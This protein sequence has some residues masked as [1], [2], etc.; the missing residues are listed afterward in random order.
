MVRLFEHLR[1]LLFSK[2]ANL[3][4]KAEKKIEIRDCE[5]D[6]AEANNETRCSECDNFIGKAGTYGLKLDCFV[7]SVDNISLKFFSPD[8]TNYYTTASPT[9][10]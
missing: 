3:V 6:L 8:L 10:N 9:V 7:S 4:K 2:S 1:V 5:D